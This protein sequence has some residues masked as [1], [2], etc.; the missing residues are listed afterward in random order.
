M[1]HAN[2]TDVEVSPDGGTVTVRVPIA[3][4]RRGCRKVV[5]VPGG[6]PT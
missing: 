5:I 4:R 6:Q 3:F 2:A 1:Q